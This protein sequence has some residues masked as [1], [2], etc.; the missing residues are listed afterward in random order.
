[1]TPTQM[2]LRLGEALTYAHIRISPIEVVS[3]HE[4]TFARLFRGRPGVFVLAESVPNDDLD[5][6]QDARDTVVLLQAM[7]PGRFV[8]L[9][10]EGP[11]TGIAIVARDDFERRRA[12]VEGLDPMI[13]MSRRAPHSA[14][15]G[16]AP[17][18]GQAPGSDE[19]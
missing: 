3:V 16:P 2:M 15:D 17:V 5:G 6:E 10:I 1:M 12:D 8:M 4:E 7:A 11:L 19:A 13:R 9:E 18:Y 14:E